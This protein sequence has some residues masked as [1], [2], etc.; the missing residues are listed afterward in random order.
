MTAYYD[1]VLQI[2]NGAYFWKEKGQNCGVES[3]KSTLT[4]RPGLKPLC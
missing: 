4:E 3:K 2:K 1:L